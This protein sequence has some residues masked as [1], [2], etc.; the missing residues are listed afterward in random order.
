V[1]GTGRGA[2]PV[3][4]DVPLF[5]D[6]GTAVP[7]ASGSSASGPPAVDATVQVGAVGRPVPQEAGPA[8]TSGAPRSGTAPASAAGAST[9]EERRTHGGRSS[10]DA[11]TKGD[12]EPPRPERAPASTS[13]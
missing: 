1:R 2:E 12:P 10:D 5:E 6:P 13:R 4:H 11:T 7:P 3:D 8:R 9:A